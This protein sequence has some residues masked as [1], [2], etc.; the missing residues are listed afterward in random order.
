MGFLKFKSKPAANLLRLPAGCFTVDSAGKI[1][2]STLPQNFPAPLVN[3]IAAH[4]LATFRDAAAAQLPL[5]EI[6][7]RFAS[8]KLTARE[9]RGGAIVFLAPQTLA[10][11]QT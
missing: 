7:V 10:T 4:V 3:E 1:V 2:A 9:M 5:T 11:N 6:V 8:L